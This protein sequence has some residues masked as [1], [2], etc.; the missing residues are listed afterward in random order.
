ME[1]EPRGSRSV[2]KKSK[3]YTQSFAFTPQR[4]GRAFTLIPVRSFLVH[5]KTYLNPLT[6]LSQLGFTQRIVGVPKAESDAI[7]TF[8][9]RQISENPDFQVRFRWEV[10]SVAFWDNRVCFFFCFFC[11][12]VKDIKFFYSGCDS[13][14]H[15]RFLACHALCT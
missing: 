8:L 14:S 15:V 6:D 4:V 9:F 3:P 10:N 12:V 11:N 7:L 2:G 13:F 1:T 5:E